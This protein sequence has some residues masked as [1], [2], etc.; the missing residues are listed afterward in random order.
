MTPR[1]AL[2]LGLGAALGLGTGL[3]AGFGV[4]SL[5][6]LQRKMRLK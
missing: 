6:L 5:P 4:G 2:L 3:I 1:L